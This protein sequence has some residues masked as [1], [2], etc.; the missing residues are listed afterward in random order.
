LEAA[1]PNCTPA[2]RESPR[3]A[4]SRTEC[5]INTVTAPCDPTSISGPHR[6]ALILHLR[7]CRR[8][9]FPVSLFPQNRDQLLN[10]LTAMKLAF[11]IPMKS[12][13][14]AISL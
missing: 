12:S 2:G 9:V 6:T 3:R 1:V 4:A 5:G 14:V 13:P 8:H 7:R 11:P 10:T